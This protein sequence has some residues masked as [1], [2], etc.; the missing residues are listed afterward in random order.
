MGGSRS[1]LR[2]LEDQEQVRVR[3]ADRRRDFQFAG[4]PD[5]HL[6]ERFDEVHELLR[7]IGKFTE[8]IG[9]A[10]QRFIV[11]TIHALV[12]YKHFAGADLVLL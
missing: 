3:F 12:V 8:E 10:L 2:C 4:H 9:D 5:A 11:K 6:G 7:S 1:A